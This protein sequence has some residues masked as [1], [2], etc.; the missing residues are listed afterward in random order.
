[1]F[2]LLFRDV[3]WHF[4]YAWTTDENYSHG[5]L[6]PLIAVYFADQAARRGPV[7]V[8]GGGWLGGVD[9]GRRQC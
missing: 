8:R 7:P 1:M 4:Y 9:A 6:V 3:L 5:F 2:G